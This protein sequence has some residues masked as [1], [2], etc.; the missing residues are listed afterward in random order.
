MKMLI[1]NHMR[2]LTTLLCDMVK[3]I[4]KPLALAFSNKA[5]VNVKER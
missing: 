5:I 2:W 1:T 4:E 3:K